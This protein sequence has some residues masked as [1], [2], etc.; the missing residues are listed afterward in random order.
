M[1][2]GFRALGVDDDGS[3]RVLADPVVPSP[4][5][6]SASARAPAPPR[7][8]ARVARAWHAGPM[9]PAGET[10]RVSDRPLTSAS[11]SP[12]DASRFVVGGTDHAAYE[13]EIPPG[14]PSDP[15]GAP[16]KPPRPTPKPRARRTLYGARVGHREWVTCVAHCADGRPATGGMDS[17]ILLWDAANGAA[18]TELVGH[19]GSVSA[20]AAFGPTHASSG[21]LLA[22]ASYDKTIRIWG[23]ASGGTPRA[24]GSA[25]SESESEAFAGK[26]PALRRAASRV[27]VLSKRPAGGG[28][29]SVATLAAHAAPVLTLA[30]RGVFLASGDRGGAAALWDASSASLVAKWDGAHRGHCVSACFVDAG[31]GGCSSHESPGA[32][33]EAESPGGAYSSHHPGSSSA[34]PLL[35]TGGQDGAVRAWDA[36]QRRPAAETWAHARA[37]GAGAASELKQLRPGA[38]GAPADGFARVASAGAD[39]RVCALDP[40]AGFAVVGDAVALGDFAY[41]LDVVEGSGLAVVGTGAGDVHVV[42]VEGGGGAK[43]KAP[44][45]AGEGGGGGF[46]RTLY[47]LGATRGGACRAVVADAEG[48]RLVVAGDDGA[49]ATYAFLR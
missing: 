12:A 4:R 5:E 22:S 18:A 17:R 32:E 10:V 38:R 7:P 26:P 46:P 42:D 36:R 28:V 40:R 2:E 47:A 13:L 27:K 11:R 23:A 20:L 21:L 37:G 44:E 29:A 35:L 15:G 14:P 33:E 9:A 43:E 49:V 8:P 25:S 48:G 30:R 34:P 31:P 41:C 45:N 19:A 1:D 39:G 3:A 16:T 6:P 24:I